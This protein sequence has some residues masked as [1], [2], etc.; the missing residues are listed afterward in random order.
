M[1]ENLTY[2]Q[3]CFVGLLIPMFLILPLMYRSCDSFVHQRQLERP[4]YDNSK[5]S[6]FLPVLIISPTITFLK[7]LFKK[8][9]NSFFETRL[10]KK[11]SGESLKLKMYKSTRNFFKLFWFSFITGLGFYVLSDTEFHTPLMFG[12][13]DLKYLLSDWPFTRLPRFFKL[14]Y[15][16]GLSYHFEDSVSHFFH[17]I[18]NDFFEMLLHHYI[19]ILLI[20][21]SYMLSFWNFGIIVM[22]QMDFWDIVVSWIK[23][24]MDLS[25]SITVFSNYLWMLFSWIYF[26]DFVFMY[27]VV[28]K[29][30]MSVRYRV[31]YDHDSRQLSFAVLLI[32]LFILNMYWTILFLRM[33][34]RF[35]FKGETKDIQNP[36]EDVKSNWKENK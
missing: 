10:S 1:K 8:A 2:G 3:M 21:S 35:I 22:I 19:T 5:W 15:M 7:Y 16:I 6:D 36:I 23:A 4:D 17:P 18:Q 13:G 28:W 14:Y 24:F 20:V 32:G 34:Y 31:G 9:S 25:S 26:R 12:T 29:W 30:S 33:G 11:Y 27:E